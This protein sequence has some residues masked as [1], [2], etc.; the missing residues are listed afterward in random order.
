M[1]APHRKVLKVVAG[2]V[3]V[4]VV[5]LAILIP[6]VLDALEKAKQKRA[7]ADIR[8]VGTA[9]F[10]WLTDQVD[11]QPVETASE[12]SST[13]GSR[14][15]ADELSTLFDSASMSS[16]TELRDKDPW[17]KPY[18]YTYAD[19]PSAEHVIQIRCFGRD[20]KEGPT[21]PPYTAGP[22]AATAYDEDIVWAD[23]FF[24]RYPAGAQVD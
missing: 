23:G 7:V 16:I 19:S 10:S 12:S 9:W 11:D 21:M 3:M 4:S 17:G 6:N 20:G 2:S 1:T 18:E 22:F 13:P 5:L 24:V 8:T 15:G 14:E